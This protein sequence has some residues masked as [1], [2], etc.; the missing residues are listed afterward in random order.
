MDPPRHCTP[1]RRRNRTN[2]TP[3]RRHSGQGPSSICTLRVCTVVPQVSMNRYSP[4][5]SRG[6]P[7]RWQFRRVLPGLV[8]C[9]NWQIKKKSLFWS[10]ARPMSF[11]SSS[12]ARTRRSS[13]P[14][15]FISI[16]LPWY[17]DRGSWDHHG[18]EAG[19]AARPFKPMTHGQRIP[20]E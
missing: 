1:S 3:S 15:N 12:D 9:G 13:P 4:G 5:R 7:G 10:S 6:L 18:H 19:C 17:I 16:D 11:V 20:S 8:A 2:C 14:P